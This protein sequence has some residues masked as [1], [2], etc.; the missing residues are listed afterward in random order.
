M[1]QKNQPSPNRFQNPILKRL[2]IASTSKI[3]SIAIWREIKRH[4]LCLVESFVVFTRVLLQNRDFMC[5][6]LMH[7]FSN[8]SPQSLSV[9][10]L[11]HGSNHAREAAGTYAKNSFK[12]NHGRSNIGTESTRMF[13]IENAMLFSCNLICTDDLI[14]FNMF[15]REA[16][17]TCRL[18]FLKHIA[19]QNKIT[20]LK[21]KNCRFL[22][23]E[24][25]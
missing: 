6:A 10:T 15:M 11:Q 22:R 12:Q 19:C 21:M 13:F 23:D 9:C 16:R 18:R 8:Y 3:I 24:H 17:Q 1:L 14:L 5:R 4:Y 20:Y 2:P 7:A 25:E